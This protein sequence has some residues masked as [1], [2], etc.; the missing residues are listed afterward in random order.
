MLVRI[1]ATGQVED[2]APSFAQACIASGRGVAIGTPAQQ[3]TV[4]GVPTIETAAIMPNVPVAKFEFHR[5]PISPRKG[6][7]QCPR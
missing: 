7:V 5:G 1:K 4:M 3:P 6:N 2:F